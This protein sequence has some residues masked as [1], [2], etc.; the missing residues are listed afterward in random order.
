MWSICVSYEKHAQ[1]V[2]TNENMQIDGHSLYDGKD[3]QEKMCYADK[4]QTIAIY[5]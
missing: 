2:L 4:M 5:K 3:K 1:F